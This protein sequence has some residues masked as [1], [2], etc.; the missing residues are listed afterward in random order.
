M[1]IG[2]LDTIMSNVVDTPA[3]F[4]K[5]IMDIV[6]KSKDAREMKEKFEKL[7]LDIEKG[8]NLYDK[9]KDFDAK[10]FEKFDLT[11]IYKYGEGDDANR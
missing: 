7:S 3:S 10:V 6:V 1:V 4:E 9:V 8:K 2:E 11:P 5:M